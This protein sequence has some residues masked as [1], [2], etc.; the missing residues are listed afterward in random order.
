MPLKYE[1]L[2][3][4]GF[5]LAYGVKGKAPPPSFLFLVW[6]MNICRA[7]C[8]ECHIA[9]M[10]DWHLQAERPSPL[11]RRARAADRESDLA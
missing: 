10:G 7:N 6:M 3:K 2:T 8:A 11:L 1:A 4:P 5:D 9:F